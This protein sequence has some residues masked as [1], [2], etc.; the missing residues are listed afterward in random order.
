[1]LPK[2][3]SHIVSQ[4]LVLRLLFSLLFTASTTHLPAQDIS[5][6]SLTIA[7]GLSQGMIYDI[8]QTEDG[9]MWFST[10]DGLNRYDGYTFKVYTNDPFNLYSIMGNEVTRLFEDSRG[11]LW[12]VVLGKGIDVLE[13]A[14]GRFLHLPANVYSDQPGKLNVNCFIETS[15]STIWIGTENGLL[16]ARWTIGS[17]CVASDPDLRNSVSVRLETKGDHPGMVGFSTLSLT[18]SKT[19]L[20]SIRDDGIYRY[21]PAAKVLTELRKRDID[22]EIRFTTKSETAWL[23]TTFNERDE[24]VM[25]FN[26][27]IVHDFPSLEKKPYAFTTMPSDKNG[28]LIWTWRNENETT[29]Y[30][31]PKAELFKAHDALHPTRI[32]TLQENI[33]CLEIDDAGN[34]WVGMG[35]YGVRKI[36]LN[37]QPFEHYLSGNSVRRIFATDS[38]LLWFA[39]S[40]IVWKLDE[41]Q[42]LAT[43]LNNLPKNVVQYYQTRRGAVYIITIDSRHYY[44]E[45]AN[46]ALP[47]PKLIDFGSHD[48]TPIIEDQ[49]GN[50]WCGSNDAILMRF[51]VA[52]K[53][54]SFLDISKGLGKTASVYAL[55]FD[56]RG[57]LWVGTTN[58]LAQIRMKDLQFQ[59]SNVKLPDHAITYYQNDPGNSSS[60]RSNFVSSFCDDP[61]YPDQYIWIGTKGG[62]LS[63]LDKTTKTFRHFNSHNSGLPNDVVYAMLPDDLGHIWMSTNRGLSRMTSQPSFYESINSTEDANRRD[64]IFHN[65]RQTDGLQDDE[66]NTSAAYRLADGRLL[67]GGVNGLTSFYPS[68]ITDRSFDARVVITGLKVNNQEVDY[69]EK[70]S[71]L[72][73]PVHLTSDVELTYKQNLVTI[74]FALMDFASPHENRFRYRLLGVDPDWVDSGLTHTANYAQIRP[75]HYT[76]EVQGNIGYGDWSPSSILRIR[77]IPPWWASWWALSLY[78]LLLGM[79]WYIIYHFSKRRLQ[80]KRQLKL[81]FEEAQRLQELDTFKSRLFTNL[82]HEFRTPLTVILGMTKQ[83]TTASWKSHTHDTEEKKISTALQLIENSGKNLLHLINQL[84][85]LFKLE[86]KSFKLQM[87]QDNIIPYLRYVSEA[88]QS[89]ANGNNLSL[90]FFSNEE[91]VMMDFDP[92][93]IRYVLTNLISNAL[94]FTPSGGDISV[95]VLKRGE[96]LDI[97]VTD[98]GIGISSVDLPNIFDRFYQ[99][100]S[101]STRG[102]EGTGIGLAHTQELVKIMNGHISV[103]SEMGKGT[104]VLVQLPITNQAL[105]MN[106]LEPGQEQISMPGIFRKSAEHESIIWQDPVVESTQPQILII[107]DNPDV[108][109]Y[110]KSCLE[111]DY[112]LQVAYNGRIGIEKAI[113]HIPDLVIS[114]VMM[115]EKDGYQVCNQLKSDERTSHIPIIL[116]TA[117]ADAAS[118]M[119]GLRRGADVYL[120]KPFDV[121]E[122][123]VQISVLLDNRQRVATH[124]SKKYQTLEEIPF[125]DSTLNEVIGVEDAFLQKVNSIIEANYQ[126]EDFSLILMCQ[127]IGMS[128]SQLFRKMK[129]VANTSPSDLIRSYR[130]QK[131]K[132]ILE[133]GEVTVGEAA[134]QVG[135]K[136]PSYFTK[137]FYEEFGLLPSAMLK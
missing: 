61:Y 135:F 136:D 111:K 17:Q 51:E 47:P 63:L 60:L 38:M 25:V 39:G 95:K 82:T 112:Q 14:T 19:Q 109:I 37:H 70:D 81:K 4:T 16:A 131:A 133:T 9:F 97:S 50:L 79:G 32:C 23:W 107:E 24:Y 88:F 73:K 98:T 124:F 74:D 77:I 29:I 41:Y 1:M 106:N 71:P 96:N 55:H 68:E 43:P 40:D 18:E 22:T 8:E 54:Y 105:V 3:I 11:N 121:E 103:E 117:K 86:N 120:A 132:A 45:N 62:G 26:N 108:V 83:L 5:I 49:D 6:E 2:K 123:L 127:Y 65:F 104:S 128:R 10:K 91:M 89:Y 64:L 93:Q 57:N 92:E 67:F 7:D 85:D 122:L 33:S 126:D 87:I 125:L 15:D 94:K 102:A 99:A 76:F 53:K 56:P 84:L 129:A 66:F 119:V 100:D 44:L 113:E 118:R 58:G 46:T 75:G 35:G 13:K 78:C 27:E 31:L 36:R 30:S 101:T 110:L 90:N 28:N 42:N 80:L 21:D 130:L 34:L 12:V 115:P 72:H 134:Y 20:L 52:T 116:L 48:Y 59:T 114:D 69:F 137:I